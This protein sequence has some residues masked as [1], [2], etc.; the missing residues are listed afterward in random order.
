[1]GL[2]SRFFS[3]LA[4][5]VSSFALLTFGLSGTAMSRTEPRSDPIVLP[6]I[7]VQVPK[8]VARP[9]RPQRRA[10]TNTAR[11]LRVLQIFL[12]KSMAKEQKARVGRARQWLARTLPQ[13]TE[14]RVSQMM[15]LRWAGGSPSL[16]ERC[17]AKLLSEQRSDGG[18]AQT[19]TRASDAYATGEVLAAQA[20][21]TDGA[22]A[23]VSLIDSK[24]GDVYVESFGPGAMRRPGM[25]RW[26]RRVK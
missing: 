6:S 18:W 24:R 5:A 11:A 17:R 16:I 1:M 9:Q 8:P 26:D 14:E 23:V 13:D 21:A 4:V 7:T 22:A 10:V 3:S 15:G 12:P 2:S 25:T 19:A 20:A